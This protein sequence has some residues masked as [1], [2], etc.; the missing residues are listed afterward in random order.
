MN[1]DLRI[2]INLLPPGYRPPRQIF[3]I[4][5][6][7]HV[8]IYIVPPEYRPPIL[9]SRFAQGN[10]W[11]L[12]PFTQLDNNG[13]I[14]P[15]HHSN[16]V[17]VQH[18]TQ[19]VQRALIT[20]DRNNII[21]FDPIEIDPIQPN[22]GTPLL[23][24][25]QVV[26]IVLHYP[27][28]SYIEL[29]KYHQW[30]QQLNLIRNAIQEHQFVSQPEGHC[31]HVYDGRDTVLQRIRV[32]P[33]VYEYY[34]SDVHKP[35]KFLSWSSCSRETATIVSYLHSVTCEF[36]SPPSLPKTPTVYFGLGAPQPAHVYSTTDPSGTDRFYNW[37]LFA[38][39]S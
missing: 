1:Q 4:P 29:N 2:D 18:T 17:Y 36:I 6:G 26:L 13:Q 25:D 33:L 21:S 30:Q 39:G 7:R 23:I 38:G 22:E 15:Y 12:N 11:A 5:E 31:I 19:Q 34:A 16:Q 14:V 32:S 35:I 27:A 9:R 37:V 24:P 20:Y 10:R 3:F 28:Q 8:D